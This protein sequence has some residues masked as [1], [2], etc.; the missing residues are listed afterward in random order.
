MPSA[1]WR[2]FADASWLNTPLPANPK[3]AV[4][5]VDGENGNSSALV[6]S[7]MNY[8]TGVVRDIKPVVGTSWQH[9]M[10]FSSPTDPVWT[11]S[12]AHSTRNCNQTNS[13]VGEQ[14]HIPSGATVPNGTDMQLF[15]IDQASGY[16]YDLGG[17][18]PGQVLTG[19][20]TFYV[21]LATKVPLNGDGRFSCAADSACVGMS[22]GQVR[23][24]ELAAGS[25]NHAIFIINGTCDNTGTPTSLY[26]AVYY[27]S[28][29]GKS[30]GAPKVGQWYYLALSDAQIA[31]TGYP[32][33]QQ[34]ILRAL[35]HYG[36]FVGDQGSNGAFDIFTEDQGTWNSFKQGNPWVGYAQS[37]AQNSANNVHAAASSDVDLGMDNITHSF[38]TNNLR[39]VSP[40]VIQRTCV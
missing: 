27:N 36:M 9:A 6:A 22:A 25:I 7:L 15:V 10:Y 40:C 8:G 23:A 34:T 4:S 17:L 21:S 37:L 1:C 19:G 13:A 35:A 32:A 2:P 28:C 38:W 39:A 20:G 12:C 16:E 5:G 29:G 26:P 33:W 30:P 24:S 18:T 31:A 3:V 14:I 11:L